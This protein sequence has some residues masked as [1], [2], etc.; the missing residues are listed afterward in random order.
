[1][2][3]LEFTAQLFYQTMKKLI[4]VFSSVVVV[5]FQIIFRAE[6]HAN[7]IFLFLKNYF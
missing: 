3:C 4:R 1:V 5:V 2:G 7:D 6:M